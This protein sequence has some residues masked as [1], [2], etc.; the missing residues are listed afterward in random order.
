MPDYDRA[1]DPRRL[2]LRVRRWAMYLGFGIGILLRLV[3]YLVLRADPSTGPAIL[4]VWASP[5]V[6]G[7]ILA[8]VPRTSSLGL[9]LLAGTALSWIIGVPTCVVVTLE[10]IPM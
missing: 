1:A 6:I 9:G 4:I 8:A 10:T 5:V 7:A 3:V 2:Q